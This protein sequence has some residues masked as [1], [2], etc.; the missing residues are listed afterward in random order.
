MDTASLPALEWLD[1]DLQ[2]DNTFDFHIIDAAILRG[3]P[4]ALPS[5]KQLYLSKCIHGEEGVS[6]DELKEF[7]ECTQTPLESISL[8]DV[9]WISDAHVEAFCPWLV[10]T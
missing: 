1:I 6:P 7:F 2:S 3:L 9:T 8:G 10:N 4:T 5:L